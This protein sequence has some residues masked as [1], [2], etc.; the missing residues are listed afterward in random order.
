M[1]FYKTLVLTGIIATAI[2]ESIELIKTL[3]NNYNEQLFF[4]NL[5][6]GLEAKKNEPKQ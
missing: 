2:K 5:R 6:K 3:K 4:E 1:E